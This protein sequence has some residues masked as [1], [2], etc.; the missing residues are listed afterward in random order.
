MTARVAPTVLPY[1][2]IVS[3]LEAG[4]SVC[5]PGCTCPCTRCSGVWPSDGPPQARPF[6]W[7]W[8]ICT[9]C[10]AHQ[11]LGSSVFCV[12]GCAGA[13]T[14]SHSAACSTCTLTLAKSTPRKVTMTSWPCRVAFRVILTG[15]SGNG[16]VGASG[17]AG[18]RLAGGWGVQLH[19]GQLLCP[20]RNRCA[21][22]VTVDARVAPHISAAKPCVRVSSHTAPQ[23]LCPC[24]GY[25]ASP[26]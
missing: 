13:C 14:L 9:L 21:E 4:Q 19:L 25:V 24:H 1:G 20:S 17:C 12:G 7:F 3:P 10:L 2:H 8:V 23:L 16:A 6:L 26:P 22:A 5:L 15:A 18:W 11:P